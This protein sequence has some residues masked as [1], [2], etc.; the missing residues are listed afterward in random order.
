MS[1]FKD[2]SGLRFGMLLVIGIYDK[3]K[4]KKIRWICKCDCGNTST[5]EAYSLMS[6][7][8][9]S[10]GCYIR[11]I[12]RKRNI[13]NNPV[14]YGKENHGFKHGGPKL[15]PAEYQ[16]WVDMRRRCYR[17]NHKSYKNYGGRGITIC[18]EWLDNFPQFYADMGKRTS[19]QHSIDRRNNEKGYTPENCHWAT[20]KEQL[21][22]RR[23]TIFITANGRKQSLSAWSGE[24]NVPYAR[25]RA[26]VRYGWSGEEIIN[27]KLGEKR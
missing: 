11:E 10:C 18:T 6:K 4:G 17:V 20:I 5:P 13:T 26:R 23:N 15:H 25:L 27:T 19:D 14:K 12:T 1:A 24:I 21:N 9:K 2:I 22:N 16:V 7:K 3:R 8:T